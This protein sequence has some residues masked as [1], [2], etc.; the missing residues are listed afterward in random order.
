MIVPDD[1]M[2]VRQFRMSRVAM[3]FVLGS[4]LLLLAGLASATTALLV[5]GNSSRADAAVL[6]K[7]EALVQELEEMGGR[8]DALH[9]TLDNL[10]GQ[11][12]FYR[13]L[14][15][16]EPLDPEVLQAGIGGPDGN[17]LEASA[18][19]RV[20]PAAGVRA[21][22]TAVEMDALI[23]RAGVLTA[24]WSEAERTLRGRHAQLAAT[25]SILPTR[26]RISSSFSS[27]RWHPILD[28]A[29][30]HNGLDI[31]APT[32]TPVVASA[33]GRVIAAGRSGH[34]GLLVEIDH[35][36]G[37]VTRYAHLSRID[38][39]V[40][41]VVERGR[42]IGAVGSTGL[43]IGP[44]LHYEVLVNGRHVNPGNYL[45]DMRGMAL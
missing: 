34:Y 18:L 33:K 43:S 9:A 21:F 31:V 24:S 39:K 25:P 40:G 3:R 23:R 17:S 36:Y 22:N 13:L 41:Q 28:R 15:G 8:V 29:R 7:N 14:A 35:G 4:A 2:A 5:A 12:A 32:G 37:T 11:D 45:L 16:L 10:T 44:H 6:A 38:V 27:S 26:G 1:D 20:D 19:Y 30:P 42:D